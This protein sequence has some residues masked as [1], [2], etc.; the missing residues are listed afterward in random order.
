MPAN[1][2]NQVA[3]SFP[4]ID[5]DEWASLAQSDPEKF[6][7]RRREI[8]EAAISRNPPERQH[9]LR[10]LQWK[11]DQIRDRSPT[12]LSAC[13]KISNM[14]WNSL[15]GPGGLK[16]SLKQIRQPTSPRQATVLELYPSKR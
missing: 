8:I 9:R 2:N 15:T 11:I 14:M 1:N 5:F 7:T 10:C 4:K 16:E 13:V 3:C 6:E 12:P